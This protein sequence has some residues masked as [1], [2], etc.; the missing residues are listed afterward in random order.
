MTISDAILFAAAVYIIGCVLIVLAAAV[1]SVVT[2]ERTS[3]HFGPGIGGL[4]VL[5]SFICAVSVF[6]TVT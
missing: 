3:I 4:F 1:T 6:V 2:E 5:S